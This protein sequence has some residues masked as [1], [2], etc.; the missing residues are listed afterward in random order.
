[1]PRLPQRP[2]RLGPSLP[3]RPG[4]SLKLFMAPWEGKVSRRCEHAWTETLPLEA[5]LN[6]GLKVH[7]RSG[8]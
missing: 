3:P 5:D 6:F 7:V 1:M 4:M 2:S 8:D